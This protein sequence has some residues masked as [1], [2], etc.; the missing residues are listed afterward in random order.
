MTASIDDLFGLPLSA[1][2]TDGDGWLLALDDWPLL[3]LDRHGAA[4]NDLRASHAFTHRVWFEREI[5]TGR[6]E[7]TSG[8]ASEQAAV[9]MGGDV[10][11]VISCDPSRRTHAGVRVVDPGAG[12]P[13][14]DR[15]VRYR[16]LPPHPGLCSGSRALGR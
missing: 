13:L 1:I 6:P 4:V 8:A 5:A 3:Y 12:S 14:F 10:V 11:A 7:M 2:R 15:E 9:L 16:Q